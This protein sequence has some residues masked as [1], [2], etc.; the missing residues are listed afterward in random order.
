MFM[1]INFDCKIMVRKKSLD[2]KF[3]DFT[4]SSCL[5]FSQEL[6]ALQQEHGSYYLVNS[7]LIVVPSSCTTN[8]LET[9]YPPVQK[10]K[11]VEVKELPFRPYRFSFYKARVNERVSQI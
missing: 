6:K 11:T 9:A 7:L 4:N 5:G 10:L 8:D 3:A 2:K 1:D